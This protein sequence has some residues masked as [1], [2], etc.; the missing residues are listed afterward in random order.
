MKRQELEQAQQHQQ[1]QLAMEQQKLAAAKEHQDRAYQLDYQKTMQG[2]KANQLKD[3]I[4][5]Q[6]LQ[7]DQN[8]ENRASWDFNNKVERDNYMKNNADKYAKAFINKDPSILSKEDLA[9][10]PPRDQ[11]NLLK[12]ISGSSQDL[13]NREKGRVFDAVGDS[14]VEMMD[15]IDVDPKD[16][17]SNATEMYKKFLKTKIQPM[18]NSGMYDRK[19]IA[20]ATNYFSSMVG[21]T[22]S[23]K[24]ASIQ[25]TMAPDI[26]TEYNPMTR[27]DLPPEVENLSNNV[28]IAINN[29]GI[30]AAADVFK[31]YGVD[32]PGESYTLNTP[33]NIQRYQESLIAGKKIALQDRGKGGTL[34]SIKLQGGASKGKK[35]E[36]S[37]LDKMV[38]AAMKE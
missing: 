23:M 1:A 11:I 4:A 26:V 7:M 31:Q 32:K 2:A 21:K 35:K 6:R 16:G 14:Y 24:K 17:S 33:K 30:D 25:N 9:V 27:D 19:A 29:D 28:G 12:S 18:I 36:E 37:E 15:G 10:L 20:E 38:A 34:N 3:S 13:I 22:A 8:K 5:L